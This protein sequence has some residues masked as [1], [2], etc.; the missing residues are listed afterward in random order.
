MKL[1]HEVIALRTLHPFTIARGGSSE[2]RVVWVRLTHS[3]KHNLLGLKFSRPITA[4]PPKKP[5]KGR[6]RPKFSLR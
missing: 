5:G 1:A 2:I 6:G 4:T 3:E